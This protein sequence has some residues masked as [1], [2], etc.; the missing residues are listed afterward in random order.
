MS[1]NILTVNFD[2]IYADDARDLDT[3]RV[4]LMAT[5]SVD[6]E[7]SLNHRTGITYA[8]EVHK[9]AVFVL[10]VLNSDDD[11]NFRRFGGIRDDARQLIKKFW[12]RYN[13]SLKRD[14]TST[15]PIQNSAAPLP[16]ITTKHEAVNRNEVQSKAGRSRR[17]FTEDELTLMYQ[18]F[19]T[20]GMNA[21]LAEIYEV[22]DQIEAGHST[23]YTRW[24]AWKEEKRNHLQI[25][26]SA[27]K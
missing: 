9:N 22:A 10:S 1:K 7:T 23:V 2:D 11:V 21:T 12:N 3:A 15:P 19:D 25:T 24:T 18:L 5:E 20:I 26:R 8:I 13:I 4:Y 6:A 14:T 16:A 17:I 27:K